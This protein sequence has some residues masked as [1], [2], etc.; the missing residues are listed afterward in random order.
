[1]VILFSD[2]LFPMHTMR[3]CI[4]FTYVCRLQIYHVDKHDGWKMGAHYAILEGFVWFLKVDRLP[5]FDT[6]H[7]L[8]LSSLYSTKI[9]IL[10]HKIYEDDQQLLT[11]VY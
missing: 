11:N 8:V 1:M 7:S 10:L 4:T 5:L 3:M 6:F 2:Q 9:K